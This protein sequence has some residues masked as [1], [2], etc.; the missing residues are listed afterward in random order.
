[1]T[2]GL[3]LIACLIVAGCEPYYNRGKCLSG[4]NETYYEP[5][6]YTTIGGFMMPIGGGQGTRWVCD[7]WENPLPETMR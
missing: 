6:I 1:M 5:P 7:K 2:R 3:L 4:H